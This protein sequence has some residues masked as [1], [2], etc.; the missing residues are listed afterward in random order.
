MRVIAE[1][2]KPPS[3]L[4]LAPRAP[5]N[6]ILT[7]SLHPISRSSHTDTVYT[8]PPRHTAASLSLRSSLCLLV[9]GARSSALSWPYLHV[10]LSKESHVCKAELGAQEAEPN[11]HTYT[12]NC[13]KWDFVDALAPELGDMELGNWETLILGGARCGAMARRGSVPVGLW[14]PS[15]AITIPKTHPLEK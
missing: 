4:P 15:I 9:Y 1:T 11:E 14:R 5:Q 10:E 3:H 7:P 8:S 6:V 2:L 12:V 13:G